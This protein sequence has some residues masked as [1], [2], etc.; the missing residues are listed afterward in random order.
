MHRLAS[1]EDENGIAVAF[2]GAAPGANI[3]RHVAHAHVLVLHVDARRLFVV[4]PAAQHV[5]DA[6]VGTVGVVRG[7]RVVHGDDVG[8][9]RRPDEA[10]I[11]GGDAHQ[12][13]AFDQE[14]GVADEADAHL[15]GFKRG[16]PEGG[17]DRRQ[18]PRGD[19]AGAVAAHFR[20]V[21]GGGRRHGLRRGRGSQRRQS[22]CPDEDFQ[23]RTVH[24][25]TCT[26]SGAGESA[27]V[28]PGSPLA[29]RAYDLARECKAA[30]ARGAAIRAQRLP[31]TRKTCGRAG[32]R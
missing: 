29:S 30:P 15:I 2:G 20:F 11:V 7:V 19:Q 13:R 12:L 25:I 27:T 9:H 28:W 6:G 26:K 1:L 8:Q 31:A 16:E 18:R 10:V 24:R 23:C 5:F 3:G 17:G 14:G 21:V 32:K 4:G 22:P